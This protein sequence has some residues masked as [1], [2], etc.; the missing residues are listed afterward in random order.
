MQ[1]ADFEIERQQA[2]EELTRMLR[3]L[4]VLPVDSLLEARVRGELFSFGEELDEK[5]KKQFALVSKRRDI[6]QHFDVL[7]ELGKVQG[8]HIGQLQGALQQL[9]AEQQSG[10]T[11]LQSCLREQL[12]QFEQAQLARAEKLQS[13][14]SQQAHLQ[15]RQIQEAH[16]LQQE[17]L[18]RLAEKLDAAQGNLT[19]AGQQASRAVLAELKRL[20][21][22]QQTQLQVAQSEL[23]GML[24]TLQNRAAV[25]L[26][27]VQDWMQQQQISLDAQQLEIQNLHR[28]LR[29]FAWAGLVLVGAGCAGI[30]MLVLHTPT[31]R[32]L[33]GLPG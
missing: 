16:V 15:G 6:S 29:G 32:A 31:L 9:A 18:T 21:A 28:T 27:R 3:E 22:E 12:C 17:L 33:L 19:S 20:A 24:D 25:D 26:L 8:E 4:V 10:S 23:E 1:E 5:L 2:D 14:L 30:L 7:G 11:Q 13:E